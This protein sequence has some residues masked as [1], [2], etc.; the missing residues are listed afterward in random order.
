MGPRHRTERASLSRSIAAGPST[1]GSR[2]FGRRLRLAGCVGLARGLGFTRRFGLTRRLRLGR[3]L[4]SL[5][6]I[7]LAVA[8]R[9]VGLVLLAVPLAV[10][11]DVPATALELQ[12]RSGDQ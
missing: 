1:S 3:G 12:S 7:A 10:I 4:G 8:I 9:G 2:R 6:A 5:G 11:V